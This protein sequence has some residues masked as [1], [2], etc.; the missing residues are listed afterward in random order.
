MSDAAWVN[1]VF[2]GRVAPADRGLTLGDGVFDTLVAFAGAPYAGARHL[3][4]LE[5]QA[6]AIGIRVDRGK[7]L[8]GWGPALARAGAEHVILR[9][10]V[11]RG[12]AG[13]GLWPGAGDAVAPEPTLVVAAAPWTAD[14]IGQPV[15]LVTSASRR[16]AS[17]PS[18]RLKSLGYLDN[19]LAA[20]EAA[21]AGATDALILNTEGRVAST[22]IANCFAIF[23]R[24]VLTPPLA[25]GVMPGIMRGLALEAARA[26]GFDAAECSLTP[27]DLARA[28]SVFVSNSVR[29]LSAV[30]A[31]DG[32]P[33]ATAGAPVIAKLLARLTNKDG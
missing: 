21:A 2:D 19:I 30:V 27:D 5:A 4:R 11:T 6:A 28:D 9:T 16:S 7:V 13:R 17:A 1:G 14:L 18:S 15:R 33:L 3:D 29:F 31:L 10:T 12:P 32:A 22:T 20:R 26:D 24:R 8:A 23:G 25:D